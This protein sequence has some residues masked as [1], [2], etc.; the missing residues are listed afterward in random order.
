MVKNAGGN[1]AKGFARKHVNG[2]KDNELRIS[3]E[4]GEIY[5]VVTNM[6]GGNMFQCHC[7]DGVERLCHI[8]GSFSGRKK[9]D[10]IVERGG[11]V[12]IGIREWDN[13]PDDKPPATNSTT[14][15]AKLPQCDLLEVYSDGDKNRL[16]DSVKV[17][18]K[19]LIKNDPT[20]IYDDNANDDNAFDDAD[21]DEFEGC[22]FK[23]VTENDIDREKLLKE[24]QSATSEKIRMMDTTEVSNEE[25]V[26]FEDL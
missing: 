21:L 8:R 11:W 7:I 3:K 25:M 24:A 22:G 5:A 1:K 19:I 20:K 2:N 4:D 23:F 12:L 18:W 15:K 17:N 14:K 13:K 6:C 16:R 9:R 10:N 26:S